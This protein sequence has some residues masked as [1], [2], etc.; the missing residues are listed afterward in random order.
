MHFSKRIIYPD[1]TTN[2]GIG[3][4]PPV[5]ALSSI[6]F[7]SSS[8]KRIRYFCR[9]ALEHISLWCVKYCA[10]KEV[11][12]EVYADIYSKLTLQIKMSHKQI[13]CIKVER[14]SQI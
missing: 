1:K 4:I 14:V 3:Y 6:C 5:I 2:V 13:R 8:V 11:L 12:S 7:R 10:L 9:L